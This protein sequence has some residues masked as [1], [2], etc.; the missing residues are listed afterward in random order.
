M[1][2]GAV[3]GA[4][5]DVGAAMVAL[6]RASPGLGVLVMLVRAAGAA[7]STGCALFS[8]RE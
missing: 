5:P 7:S 3:S 2:P 8:T 6:C 1:F 4:V